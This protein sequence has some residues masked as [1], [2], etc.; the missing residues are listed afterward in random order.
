MQT[1]QAY[2]RRELAYGQ[3]L[4]H[5]HIPFKD[6]H[7]QQKLTTD[8]SQTSCIDYSGCDYYN[9]VKKVLLTMFSGGQ[10]HRFCPYSVVSDDRFFY[11]LKST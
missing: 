10:N 8:F 6:V 7:S 9:S 11:N 4:I 2:A 1:L 5:A 3:A